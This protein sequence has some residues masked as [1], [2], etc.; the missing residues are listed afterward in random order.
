MNIQEKEVVVEEVG[1]LRKLSKKSR[2]A[3]RIVRQR[4]FSSVTRGRGKNCRHGASVGIVNSKTTVLSREA[5][6][7]LRKGVCVVC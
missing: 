5:P 2:M 4:K 3:R 6:G 7:L 1:K